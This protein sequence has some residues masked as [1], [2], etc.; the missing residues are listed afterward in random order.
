[1]ISD[2]EL[3]HY[4]GKQPRHIAGFKQ[5]AHDLALKGKERR[6]LEEL[7]REMTRQRKLVAIGKERWSLPTAASS[8]DL[9]VGRLRMHRD[10][11]GFVIPE[12]DSL[13]ARAQGKLAGDI[14]IPP[15]RIG[16]AMHGDE[17]LVELGPIRQD[18]RAATTTSRRLTKK[19]PWKSPSLR[20]WS[21]PAPRTKIARIVFWATRSSAGHHETQGARAPS[22]VVRQHSGRRQCHTGDGWKTTWKVWSW[23]SRS[24]SGPR[25]RKTPADGS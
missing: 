4:I 16:S 17:V 13:P 8:Q 6:R 12:R 24:S 1:M 20:G 23:K 19:W 10:G 21:A 25:P 3:L 11:Y 9:V 15:P 18:G 14:F 22:P 2:K 5:I 7:L